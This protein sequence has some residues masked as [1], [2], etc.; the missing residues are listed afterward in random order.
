MSALRNAIRQLRATAGALTHTP[1]API[2]TSR[3]LQRLEK[4]Q[5]NFVAP[6]PEEDAALLERVRPIRPEQLSNR[7][8]RRS[9]PPAWRW[10]DRSR[11]DD[12]E[13]LTR[14]TTDAVERTSRPIDRSL[15]MTWLDVFPDGNGSDVLAKAAET[16]AER[17]N[18]PYRS[19]GREFQLWDRQEGALRVG[20][21]L[22]AG[23]EPD[24]VLRRASLHAG[25]YSGNLVQSA[26]TSICEEVADSKR[27]LAASNCENLLDLLNQMGD[28]AVSAATRPLL[29]RALLK[30]WKDGPP[31]SDLRIRIQRFALKQYGDPRFDTSKWTQF[32]QALQARGY[33]QDAE[34]LKTVVLQWLN[35]AAFEIFFKLIGQSTSEPTQWA[36]REEFWRH[37]LEMNH[38]KR[39]YFMLGSDAERQARPHWQKLQE[40]GGYGLIDSDANP[41]HSAFLMEIGDIVIAE[42]THNGSC[43]FWQPEAVHRPV[44]GVRRYDG[45]LMRAT[46]KM[47]SA[48]SRQANSLGTDQLWIALPHNP[49]RVRGTR[50]WHSK[51]ARQIRDWTGIRWA[52]AEW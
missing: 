8:V 11:S 20:Q 7:E 29:V 48:A 5:A 1:A 47:K 32:F 35:R 4:W 49:P 45:S 50:G 15:V 30:P 13:W 51:F 18:W 26:L 6:D 37:Y 12:V 31:D 22:M 44:F 33:R 21:E 23:P 41:D 28:A 9:L 16:A 25:V 52:E 17:Y 46:D 42:W 36:A 27:V 3:A 14:L 38:I 40:A 43:C 19:A 34:A 2:E 39:A 10:L 24:A